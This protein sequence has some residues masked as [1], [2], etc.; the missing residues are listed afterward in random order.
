MKDA[1]TPCP[2]PLAKNAPG[3]GI[4]LHKTK[5]IMVNLVKLRDPCMALLKILN[6]PDPR[7]YTKAQ[8]VDNVN[9]P[10]IQNIINDML[11]TL[12]NTERCGGLAATQLDIKNPP[13]I[14]VIYLPADEK[15]PVCL[16][17]PEILSMEGEVQEQEGCMSVYPNDIQC[18]VKRPVKV[19]ARA[20]DRYG[21]T[22]ELEVEGYEAKLIQHEI[23]HLNG[24]LYID[25][26]SP[27]KRQLVD[28]KIRKLL[29][30]S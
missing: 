4:I 14:T 20:F 26:L 18:T 13:Y 27:F 23:D 9:D 5:C 2:S 12:L 29:K 3:E 15:R 21:Q 17:N 22:I 8:K 7:L 25:R 11:E 30:S 6:Y 19:K 28:K 10:F 24:K 16:V 1:L